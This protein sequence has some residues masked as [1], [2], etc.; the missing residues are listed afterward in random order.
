MIDPT[1]VNK[2]LEWC[3]GNKQD[4]PFN[5]WTAESIID[6]ARR[7]VELVERL[8]DEI[9]NYK[10]ELVI[11]GY[12]IVRLDDV[13]DGGDDYYWIYNKWVGLKGLGEEKTGEEHASC[14]GR[15]TLLKGF[16]PEKEYEQMVW[17]WNAN[18]FVKA[19]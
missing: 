19:I 11:N 1:K 16:I 14:V 9:I 12:E 5:K 8:N 3:I 18:N 6:M 17:V 7:S 2:R 4:Q 10:H 13:Y 15:H